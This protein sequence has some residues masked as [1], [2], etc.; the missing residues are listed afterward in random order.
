MSPAVS[1]GINMAAYVLN[2]VRILTIS[3]TA[4]LFRKTPTF[5]LLYTQKQEDGISISM[6]RAPL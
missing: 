5:F 3:H 2:Q 6:N 1:T 4:E